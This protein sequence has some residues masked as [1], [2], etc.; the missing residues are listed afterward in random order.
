M[1]NE[2]LRTIVLLNQISEYEVRI[3]AAWLQDFEPSVVFLFACF[4]QWV[5]CLVSTALRRQCKIFY[6]YLLFGKNSRGKKISK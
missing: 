2:G 4:H 3:I 1:Y 6:G 5:S